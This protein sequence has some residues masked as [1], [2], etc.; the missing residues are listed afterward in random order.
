MIIRGQNVWVG[1]LGLWLQARVLSVNNYAGMVEGLE[2]E[3]D[4]YCLLNEGPQSGQA[5]S[6][7]RRNVR[8]EEEHA[9]IILAT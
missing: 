8:T 5:F 2:E 4:Y 1:A 6:W 9:S 7:C 3:P